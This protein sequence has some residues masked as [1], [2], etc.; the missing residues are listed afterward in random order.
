MWHR[1]NV[2]H[3]GLH[4]EATTAHVARHLDGQCR[5]GGL[6]HV[7][8]KGVGP[9]DAGLAAHCVGGKG[10]MWHRGNV[11]HG[12]LHL[13]ATAAHVARHLDSQCRPGGL[14]H[15]PCQGIGPLQR[16]GGAIALL[17]TEPPLPHHWCRGGDARG[18]DL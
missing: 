13:E 6:H 3:G 5:P 7:S 2:A 11:A 10:G 15:V 17:Y 12:G 16:P 18:I 14:H 1:G 9:H 8:Q 4:L